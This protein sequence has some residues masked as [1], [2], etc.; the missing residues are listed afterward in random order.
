MVGVKNLDITQKPRFWEYPSERIP[1]PEETHE[2]ILERALL[3]KGPFQNHKDGYRDTLIWLSVLIRI[4]Q[5]PAEYGFSD[6]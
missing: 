1:I 3:R 4:R 2:Q 6:E 5:N